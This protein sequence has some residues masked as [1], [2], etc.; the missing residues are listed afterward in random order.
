MPWPDVPPPAG[1]EVHPARLGEMMPVAARSSEEKALELERIA[2]VEGQLA[3]YKVEVAAAFARDRADHRTPDADDRL[4]DVCEFFPDE[5][6]LILSCSR[7]E[8]TI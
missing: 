2:R 6:A 5:L 1:V 3:A 4:P 8:A 7:A